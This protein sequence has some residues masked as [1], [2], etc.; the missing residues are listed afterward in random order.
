MSSKSG[1]SILLNLKEL[2]ATGLFSDL[3]LS[4]EGKQFK[5]HKNILYTSSPV[6]RRLLSGGFKEAKED[7]G[8]IELEDDNAEALQTL[9]HYFYNFVYDDSFLGHGSSLSLPVKVYAIADKYEVPQLQ[10]MAAGKLKKVCDPHKDIED[11]VSTIYLI[12]Q[13][14]NPEDRTLWNIVLPVIKNNIHYLLES[15]QF[16]TLIFEMKDLNLSLLSL[17]NRSSGSAPPTVL[18]GGVTSA[19]E[20]EDYDG[21]SQIIHYGRHGPGRRLG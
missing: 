13:N 10:T 14:T 3:T 1:S 21:A 7:C 18:T 11:F 5:V 8:M 20:D 9:L 2:L 16:Q 6:F 12:D 4:C 15:E 17:L 19:E